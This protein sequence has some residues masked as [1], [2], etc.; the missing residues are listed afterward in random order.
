M[1]GAVI[2]DPLH[3]S[4]S[5]SS[6]SPRWP[7]PT[8]DHNGE[9]VSPAPASVSDASLLAP[10]PVLLRIRAVNDGHR[11]ASRAH[12]AHGVG[13]GKASVGKEAGHS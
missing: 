9:Y 2:A 4:V 13:G 11:K 7:N 10:G 8:W 3:P 12:G 6:A 5:L 1:T